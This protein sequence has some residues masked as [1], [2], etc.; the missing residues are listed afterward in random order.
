MK[1]LWFIPLLF[2][3]IG[4][5]V[6]ALVEKAQSIGDSRTSSSSIAD[7]PPA[8]APAIKYPQPD[9]VCKRPT[10]KTKLQNYLFDAFAPYPIAGAGINQ[11]ERRRNGDK[12]PEATAS[13]SGP[14]LPLRG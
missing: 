11:K 2:A 10:E 4:L 8:P 7:A 14:I 6:L 9:L 12:G 1:M 5:G 13:D 3:I